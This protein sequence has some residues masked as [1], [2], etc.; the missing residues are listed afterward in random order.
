MTIKTYEDGVVIIE[1]GTPT[2]S[3]IWLVLRG[4]LISGSQPFAKT[5]ACI[6]EGYSQNENTDTFQWDVKAEGD[7]D[8]A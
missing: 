4:N 6:G 1:R 7:T 5:F 2:N 3:A 8:I